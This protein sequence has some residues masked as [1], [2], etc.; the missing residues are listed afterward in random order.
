MMC[1]GNGL[2][3]NND[4]ISY[5]LLKQI[6]CKLSIFDPVSPNDDDMNLVDIEGLLIRMKSCFLMLFG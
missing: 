6:K 1:V 5:D 4:L 3:K 2:L